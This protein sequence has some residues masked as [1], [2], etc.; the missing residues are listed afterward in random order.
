MGENVDI[1]QFL[2]PGG[3]SA[4]DTNLDYGV[5]LLI[6]KLTRLLP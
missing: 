5:Y 6:K 1:E 3:L 2:L 4:I